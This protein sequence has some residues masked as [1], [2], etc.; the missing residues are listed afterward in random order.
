[1]SPEMAAYFAQ[2]DAAVAHAIS[3]YGPRLQLPALNAICGSKEEY[4]DAKGKQYAATKPPKDYKPARETFFD[5]L[6][7]RSA[8]INRDVIMAARLSIY[9]FGAISVEDVWDKIAH[10]F[11][12]QTLRKHW[13]RCAAVE[14]NA[15]LESRRAFHLFVLRTI[16]RTSGLGFWMAQSRFHDRYDTFEAC[17]DEL[18]LYCD[19]KTLVEEGKTVSLE[20]IHAV[21]TNPATMDKTDVRHSYKL[22]NKTRFLMNCEAAYNSLLRGLGDNATLWPARWAWQGSARTAQVQ[23]IEA[24]T[25]DLQDVPSTYFWLDYEPPRRPVAPINDPVRYGR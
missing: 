22:L 5:D 14:Q 18:P 6:D 8:H 25:H 15:S 1:M 21:D 17:Y 19:T 3:G 20:N 9:R 23:A 10:C 13:Q 2:A 24:L 11:P 7:Q 4:D 16:H 12:K